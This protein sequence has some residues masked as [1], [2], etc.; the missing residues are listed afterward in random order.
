MKKSHH[1]LI[2]IGTA[3]A[4]FVLGLLFTVLFLDEAVMATALF[5]IIMALIC[6]LIYWK[7]AD[8]TLRLF[9]NQTVALWMLWLIPFTLIMQITSSFFVLEGTDIG[10]YGSMTDDESVI[11]ALLSVIAAP[12]SEEIVFRGVIYEHLKK[13][14]PFGAALL[15]SSL[16]FGAMHGT[17]VHLYFASICG[18]VFAMSYEYMGKIRYSIFIH[19]CFNILSL[20][21]GGLNVPSFLFTWPAVIVMNI[22]VAGVLIAAYNRLYLRDHPVEVLPEE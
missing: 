3:V 11:Y 10:Y 14:M 19:M 12:V 5:D 15:V 2:V 6:G 18:I 20:V 21:C 17:L 1:I 13:I 9:S 4:F 22:I 7:T 8:H 16:L